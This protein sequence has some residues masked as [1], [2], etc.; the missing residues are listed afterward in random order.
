MSYFEN[1]KVGDEVYGFVYGKGVVKY[2]IDDQFD[3]DGFYAFSVEYDNGEEVFYTRDGVPNW[4]NSDGCIQTVYWRDDI[5]LLDEDFSPS[6]GA[7]APKKIM[8]LRVKDKLEMKCPSG[9]WRQV[10]QCPDSVFL[11][12]ITKEQYHLFRKKLS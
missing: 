12:A 11:G 7:L 8:K 5:D 1:V 9:I 4:C 6:E 3:M 2:V 10:S